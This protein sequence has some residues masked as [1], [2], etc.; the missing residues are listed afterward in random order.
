MLYLLITGS[1]TQD[2]KL[3]RIEMLN[4]IAT[5]SMVPFAER[6]MEAWPLLEQALC[7]ALSRD[8][9]GR[10]P[11]TREFAQAWLSAS[12][13]EPTP[14]AHLQP[15]SKLR[16]IR[17][18]V[19]R[20]SVIDGEW[21]RQGF[22]TPPTLPINNGAAG[23]AFAL[24]R[25]S[26]ATD[27]GE[28][29]A[30]AD[31]WATRAIAA[32]DSVEAFESKPENPQPTSVGLASLQYQRPGV[33]VAQALIA[34][35]RGDL[36]TQRHANQ[37]VVA[38]GRE[39]LHEPNPPIDLT[40]GIAGSLLAAALLI[41]AMPKPFDSPETKETRAEL[42][43]FGRD[44]SA[45]L[46]TILEGYAPIGEDPGLTSFAI[47]HGWAGLLYASLLWN[48]ATGSPITDSLNQRLD[49]LAVRAQPDRRGLDWPSMQRESFPSWC[50]GSAGLVFLWTEAHKTTGESRYLA[51]AEGAAWHTWENPSRFASLCCGQ[52]G[53][54]Y[55]LL[56]LY[57]HTGEE[58]WLRRARK[59]ATWA[60]QL[61]MAHPQID[62]APPETRPGSLYNSIA[63][64]AVLDADLERPLEA[65]MPL[66]ERD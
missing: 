25:I 41:D 54:A 31:A 56:N 18:Q 12:P 9:T 45:Q 15:D 5:G 20:K 24:L 42:L 35:A 17:Q 11:S 28:L 34:A 57:R 38:W 50:N 62:D 44:L 14:A 30:V 63:G 39:A 23:L 32:I 46:W 51:L 66:F 64:L 21:M 4:Q 61:A 60:A 43:S 16:E 55:A 48:A 22:K 26:S 33:Y 58:L 29:L 49:Q 47:A 52:G 19:L 65:R 40:V 8:P 27:D 13:T 53:Q 36:S 7:R 59:M 37:K 10:Y 6:S 2:F 3:E 1:H